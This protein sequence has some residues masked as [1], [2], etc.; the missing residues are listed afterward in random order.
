MHVF[1]EQGGSVKVG[2]EVSYTIRSVVSQ[3]KEVCL[4]YLFIHRIIIR[5]DTQSPS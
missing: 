3:G 5:L 4:N 1:G 2:G